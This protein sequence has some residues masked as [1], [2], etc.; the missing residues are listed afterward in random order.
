MKTLKV[1]LVVL[2]SFLMVLY[3]IGISS[4]AIHGE[5]HKIAQR[6]CSVNEGV[7]IATP[8]EIRHRDV[9]SIEG[10]ALCSVPTYRMGALETDLKAVFPDETPPQG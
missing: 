4:I 9:V 2:I 10:G 5:R 7:M 3:S 8:L 6:L 1:L